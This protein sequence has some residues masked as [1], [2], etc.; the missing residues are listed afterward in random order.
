ME[1]P[2]KLSLEQ[3][4]ELK[5]IRE[6]VKDL[7]LVQAQDYVVEI[8]RQTMMKENLFKHLLRKA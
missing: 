2:G 4:F 7:S 6:Q 3:E 5:V 8:M 1:I